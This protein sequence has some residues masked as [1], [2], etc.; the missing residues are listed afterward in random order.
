MTSPLPPAPE[1]DVLVVGGGMV[2]ASMALA[3]AP[4]NIRIALLD[5]QPI[6]QQS[7][8]VLD[9]H[10]F[11]PRVSAITPASQAFLASLGAWD[12]LCKRRVAAYTDMQVWD[13]DGTGAIHFSAF[14]IHADALGHIVENAVIVEALYERLRQEA[15]V[16][17]LPPDSVVAFSRIAPSD[18]DGAS[19]T[20]VSLE[21]CESLRASL[22]IA[23]DGANS[24]IR[25][26]GE[27]ATR[28]WDYGHEAIV[29]TVQTAQPHRNTAIQRFMDAGTLA[30]L[31]L[32]DSRSEADGHC[33]SIVWS[34]L[35][36]LSSTLMALD[37]AAFARA[38]GQGIEHRL[39]VIVAIDKRYC[40]PLRQRHARAYVQPGI[41]LIG[42]A[43]HTIHPLAGQGVNLGFLDASAL[44]A[45]LK[46]AC[47]KRLPL[48]D[49]A[50]LRRYQRRRMAHNLAMMGVM[51]GFKH[52]FADQAL[53][54]RW[55]RNAGMS[56]L[57]KTPVLKHSLM[58]AA[59]GLDVL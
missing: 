6:A 30:F 38:L 52:L 22:V 16:T 53:P 31:P 20:V 7:P 28:E 49:L 2:G 8:R 35:P 26:L 34:V 50:V 15:A 40:V 43:A 33:C 41:A 23:A 13:A 55:L 21:S 3:L 4:L 42:D 46:R 32:R 51:E 57:D 45:E 59:M 44:A 39:G 10:Q 11:D 19:G 14:D 54:L 17:L 12:G 47:E 29:T 37:D 36:E 18:A 58:R 24:K 27:F 25:S 5:A 9:P 56:G 1:F 48:G